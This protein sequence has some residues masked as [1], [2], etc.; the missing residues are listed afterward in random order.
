M[1][2]STLSSMLRSIFLRNVSTWCAEQCP[3][4]EFNMFLSPGNFDLIFRQVYHGAPLGEEGSQ[5]IPFCC[6]GTLDK[7]N[8]I[9]HGTLPW[10]AK[11]AISGTS[12][13]QAH[14]Y[15]GGYPGGYLSAGC[16]DQYKR[17]LNNLYDNY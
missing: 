9:G 4:K 11:G 6:D 5:H 2:C 16:C 13:Y 14:N 15:F 17:K 7:L 1:Q 8:Q 10:Q 3:L 12:L